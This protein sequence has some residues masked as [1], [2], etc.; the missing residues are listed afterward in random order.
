MKIKK[1]LVANRGEIAIRIFRA[2]VEIGIKTVAIYTYEDRYSQ[3]RYKADESYQIG[4]DDEPLK[5]YLDIDEIINVAVSKGVDAI[6]P[7][8]GF[9][10]ENAEFA[11][12]CADKGIIFIGPSPQ[13]MSQLGDK[14]KAKAIAI[15]NKI[16]IIE[17]NKKDLKNHK[18]AIAEA[19]RIGFPVML[20]AASG[21]GGRGMRVIRKASEIENAFDEA[22]REAVNAFGDGTLFLEKFVEAPKHIEVQIVGDNHGNIVHLFERDCSVQRRYQKVVEMAPSFGL[23]DE[24]R[25]KLYDYALRIASAVNYNNVGTV[26][27]LVDGAGDIYFI[28]VN[29]RI[30]VEHTV[31]EMVTGIDLIK[32]QMFIAGGYKLSDTQIKIASQ[33]EIRVNGYAIQCRIT[34]EDP[35]SDFQPDYGTIITYRSAAG[36]G[37]RLDVGSLYLGVTVS[38]FFDS[39]LVKVSAHSRTLDGACRKMNRAL[40]EFRIRGVKTN[41][42]FLENIVNH[43]EFRSGGATV[44]FIQKRRELF[45]FDQRLDRAT[46]AVKYLGE[47]IVNGNPDVK[48]IDKSRKFMTPVVPAY[49]PYS[50]FPKGTKDRLTKLGP[51]GFAAWLKKEKKIHFTDTTMRDAHQSLLATRMRTYD[52]MKVAESYAKNH[53]QTFSMEVWGGATFDVCLRFLHENPWKRLAELRGAMPNILL[54]MLIRGSNGVGYSA[55]PDNLIESFVEKSWDTGVDLFRI[56]DSLNWMKNIAPCIKYVRKRTGGLAEGAIC[57]TGDIL[58]SSRTKYTLKYYL[59]LAKQIED[60]GAHMLAIKDMAGLL[61]PYAATELVTA[62]KA[63]VKIP[64]HLHTHDTS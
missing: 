30:Q 64:I 55:Y 41:V 12:K 20:K 11:R 27:F 6:H 28:E 36:F 29:P 34:T 35:E 42:Q 13:V 57:Y 32:A 4:K 40:K 56:F 19:K 33:D 26:E 5:P 50:P 58:D 37:I 59:H 38:P 31:T 49:E 16:P 53:P 63:T 43:D 46:K 25:Q 10:S 14:L 18:V 3:H 23:S 45:K 48:Y 21:G 24:T 51:E 54:Q 44:D 2:C 15:K 62:L 1:V 47:V 17:S 22:R 61:K 7:G 8:Y 39:M 60:A 9:L 52:M